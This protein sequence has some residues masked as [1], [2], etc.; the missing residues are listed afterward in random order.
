MKLLLLEMEGI[1]KEPILVSRKMGRG[2]LDRVISRATSTSLREAQRQIA[3]REVRVNDQL[4]TRINQ[5]VDQFTR[6]QVGSYELPHQTP[7]Y[8][9]MNKPQG[10]VSACKDQTHTTALDL[11]AH[12][13][14]HQLHI[15]GRLDFNSTGLLLLTNDGHWSRAISLPNSGCEKTYLVELERAVSDECIEGFAQGLYF[16][17]EGITTQAAE[18]ETINENHVKVTLREGKYHQIK[19]MFGHFGNQV[20]ALHR[21]SVGP[22]QLDSNL[23]AGEYRPLNSFE[24]LSLSEQGCSAQ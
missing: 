2:R 12:R 20:L 3:R 24:Q 7:V 6:I 10:V 8:L 11:I 18:I 19:R 1:D 14:K 5:Q 23:S 9:M 4:A 21:I 15:V 22:L 16:A 13:Q 17:Y